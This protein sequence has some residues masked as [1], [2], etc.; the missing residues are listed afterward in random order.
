MNLN[1]KMKKNKDI[2]SYGLTADR[3]PHH[4]PSVVSYVL[5][6]FYSS[7]LPRV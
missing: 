5:I 6:F 1:H 3:G 2:Y 4:E 7:F